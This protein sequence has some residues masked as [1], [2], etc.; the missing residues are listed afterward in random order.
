MPP[1]PTGKT[2]E[3]FPKT[4][5]RS[6]RLKLLL[7]RLADHLPIHAHAG[8]GEAGHGVLHYGA[9]FFHG[10][11]G[12]HLGDGGL[13]SGLDFFFSGGFGKIGFDQFDFGGFFVGHL[14][15]SA[16]GELLDGVFALLDEGGEDLVGFFVVEGGHLVD[17][18]VL[19]GGLDHAQ[20]RETVLFAGL[21]GRD[22]VFL[23]LV[24]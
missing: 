23:D 6:L 14:L 2:Y 15:A 11:G 20:G 21:H 5:L 22:D 18:F 24:D 16:F 1:V 8:G 10:G 9:H 12:G 19:E 3:M 7:H 4:P 13:H 17:F